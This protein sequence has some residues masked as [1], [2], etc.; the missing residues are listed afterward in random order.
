MSVTS[1]LTNSDLTLRDTGETYWRSFISED[2][3]AEFGNPEA[4]GSA[5]ISGGD[6]SANVTLEVQD[7][8]RVYIS[9]GEDH[10]GILLKDSSAGRWNVETTSSGDLAFYHY[11]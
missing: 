3:Y 9:A 11:S 8:S 5:Q 6:S 10:C 2:G 7:G 1:S 4:C